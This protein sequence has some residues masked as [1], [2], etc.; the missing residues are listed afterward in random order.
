G[1]SRSTLD[2]GTGPTSLGC[3]ARRTWL[4]GPICTCEPLVW[5]FER[6]HHDLTGEGRDVAAR[7]QERPIFGRG[8]E[9][10]SEGVLAWVPVGAVVD[11]QQIPVVLFVSLHRHDPGRRRQ[12]RRQAFELV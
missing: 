9:I 11:L 12:R 3:P 2:R 4:S 5:R 8:D 10:H 7:G 1:R 6:A